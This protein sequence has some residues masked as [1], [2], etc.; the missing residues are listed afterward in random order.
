MGKAPLEIFTQSWQV[1]EIAGLSGVIGE[2]GEDPEVLGGALGGENRIGLGEGLRI[3]A[4]VGGAA[5][6]DIVVAE[7]R[8][9][10]G[11]TVTRASWQ[12]EATS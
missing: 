8:F 3:E 7:R 11:G 12:S 2:P 1:L 6:C 9:E 4:R 5:A 10:A